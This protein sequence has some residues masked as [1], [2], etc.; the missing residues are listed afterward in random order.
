MVTTTNATRKIKINKDGKRHGVRRDWYADGTLKHEYAYRDG[1]PHG[2][3]RAWYDD[4][5]LRYECTYKD[6]KLIS[7][8]S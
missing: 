4:G 8:D 1:K 7:E 3:T 6:G 2:V 5:T